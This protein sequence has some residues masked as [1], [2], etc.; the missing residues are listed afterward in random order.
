MNKIKLLR[1]V[2]MFY[3]FVAFIYYAISNPP[4]EQG[5]IMSIVVLAAVIGN[6]NWIKSMGDKK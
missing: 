6:D 4:P 1:I 3:T 5:L 2:V